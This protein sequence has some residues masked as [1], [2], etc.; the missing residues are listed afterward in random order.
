MIPAPP[1]ALRAIALTGALA[2]LGACAGHA[3]LEDANPDPIGDFRMA[4]NIVVASSMQRGPLSREAT[5]Q[6]WQE[7]LTA[8]IDE[9]LG[10]FDGESM[11]H[12]ATN[13][14]GYVLAVPGIPIVAAP[15]SLLLVRVNVWD[16]STG[17]II[18]ESPRQLT[19]FEDISGGT[20]ISSGLTQ[21]REEQMENLARNAA[22]SIQTWLE[23]NRDWF[24]DDPVPEEEAEDMLA[25]FEQDV[26]LDDPQDVEP[27]RRTR[28][29]PT[30]AER[31]AELPRR[32]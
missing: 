1:A 31:S 16:D 24:G 6:E 23:A 25:E 12:I 4:H 27:P 20:L 32:R 30:A 7:A 21:S 9:R 2:L 28:R 14:D 22:R 29:Y 15:R 18:N 19:I 3:D 17:E 5:P 13:V 11:Y 26:D 8:A 10:R